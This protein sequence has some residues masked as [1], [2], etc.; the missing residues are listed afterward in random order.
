MDEIRRNI[1]QEKV[2][3]YFRGVKMID[4]V[5]ITPL[6]IFYHILTFGRVSVVEWEALFHIFHCFGLH[7]S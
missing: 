1:N 6:F 2:S 7:L 5:C 4:E 3:G